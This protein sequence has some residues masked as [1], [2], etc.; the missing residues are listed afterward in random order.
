MGALARVLIEQTYPGYEDYRAHFEALLPAFTDK[1]YVRVEGKP[2]FLIYMPKEIPDV[3]KV[4]EFWRS[5]AGRS[6]LGDLF[7][8]GVAIRE[9]AFTPKEYGFDACLR[10]NLPAIRNAKGISWRTPIRKFKAIYKGL[11]KMPT[12]YSY[13]EQISYLIPEEGRG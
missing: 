12:V 9:E 5:L 13:A 4:M 3:R 8:V 2:L 7:L 6:G 1:R 11:R 10:T